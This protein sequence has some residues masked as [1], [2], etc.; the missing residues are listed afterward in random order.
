MKRERWKYLLIIGLLLIM[1]AL[2]ASWFVSHFE[3]YQQ[4]VKTGLS[5]EARSN[6]YLAAERFL[7]ALG[8]PAESRDG[9]DL[10]LHLPPADDTLLIDRL[11]AN[12]GE[13]QQQALLDWLEAGGHL[14]VTPTRHFGKGDTQPDDDEEL[15]ESEKLPGSDAPSDRDLSSRSNRGDFLLQQFDLT[16]EPCLAEQSTAGAKVALYFTEQAKPL[17]LEVRSGYCLYSGSVEAD[18][19][20][21]DADGGIRLLQYQLGNGMMTVLSDHTILTNDKID[22]HDHALILARL[23]DADPDRH[24]WLLHDSRTAT[25]LELLWRHAHTVLISAGC[26]L[27]L[28]LW[29]LYNR[30]GPLLEP[31][32]EQRRSLLEHLDA[33]A[34][35]LWR[36]GRTGQLI[37]SVRSA[38]IQRCIEH[39]PQLDRLSDQARSEQIAKIVQLDPESIHQTLHGECDTEEQF[40]TISHHLQRLRERL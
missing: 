37:Q 38:I 6:P 31:D 27:L 36:R 18:Y 14:I 33:T 15:S 16:L 13:R 12:L 20:V 8:R 2:S 29:S 28:F 40:I 34:T 3:S 21:S 4:E 17:S 9:P 22:Q 26:L 5:P 23:T 30:A 1:T 19:Q 10:L 25:L 7:H 32:N 35:Y 11:T 39:H 24:N